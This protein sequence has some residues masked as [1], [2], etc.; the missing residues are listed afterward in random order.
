MISELRHNLYKEIEGEYRKFIR[1]GFQKSKLLTELSKK[2]FVSEV[3]IRKHCNL[4]MSD[5]EAGNDFSLTNT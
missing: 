3:S 2:Y 5:L 1:Q 4:N